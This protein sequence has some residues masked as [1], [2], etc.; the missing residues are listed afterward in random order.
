MGRIS[1][2]PGTAT[3]LQNI[4]TARTAQGTLIQK[5]N[6]ELQALEQRR[7]RER[8]ALPACHN[9]AGAPSQLAIREVELAYVQHKIDLAAHYLEQFR[10]IAQQ[11]LDAVAPRVR[12]GDAG[13]RAWE[14]LQSP[15]TQAQLAPVAR[16]AEADALLDVSQ[17]QDFIQGISKLAAR[18]VADRKAIGRVYAQAKG[19]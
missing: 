18:P 6:S 8:G 10:P 5:W 19:C 1:V 15:G 13:M 11:M 3:V 14:D 4:Q 9:E 7:L 2:F 12:H 16:S 17:V